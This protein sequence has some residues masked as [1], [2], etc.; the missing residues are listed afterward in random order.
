MTTS[1]STTQLNLRIISIVV[2]TCICYLSIGLPLAVLP[3]YIHYQLGYSPFIAGVVIS[4]QYISTLISRPHAGRYTDIWGPKKVVS[5][6]IVCCLLSGLFT[7]LAV[8]LQSSPPLA[9]AALLVGRIFLGVGESFTATGATL[10]GIKTVGAIHTSRVISWNGVATYVAMAV[11]APLG[12][13]LTGYFGISGFAAVV[14]LAAAVGLLYARTRQDVSVTAGIRA[15]FHVVARKI[16]PYGLG[17]ALGTVGFGVIATFITLYFSAHSWQGAA[18]TL[19]L[20]SIG[21]ICIRLILGNTI[22]RYGG[23]RVSLICFAIECI[24][25]LIIWSASSAWMAGM[26]AFLTGSGFSLVFPALGVEAVKQ[27]EE[28]NQ[29]T[30]LGTYSAFLDL[31]LGL[32]GPGA[33][34]VAGYYDLE[35]IYLLA[36]AVVTLAFILTLRIYLQQRAALPRT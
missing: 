1:A 30:A 28:Q 21:F 11:G 7:L 6:G 26:G 20:F 8:L 22:T 24:G 12:V 31:A 35:T 3:G 13:M 25:L 9:V 19:S 23:V 5:R 33:G 17:L 2:F 15:P 27:V 29:G 34:W 18:F 4:L 16:W 10:W 14:I 36:A 32:T